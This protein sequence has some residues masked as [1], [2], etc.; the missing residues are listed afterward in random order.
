LIDHLITLYKGEYYRQF[1]AAD[2]EVLIG[3]SGIKITGK[4]SVLLGG[5][6]ILKGKKKVEI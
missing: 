6:R 4:L 1:I 2:L 5:G 3:K